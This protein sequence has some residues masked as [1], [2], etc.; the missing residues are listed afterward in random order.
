M[1]SSLVDEYY[2]LFALSP[3]GPSG[4]F[5]SLPLNVPIEARGFKGVTTITAIYPILPMTLL[6][7]LCLSSPL[8]QMISTF[9]E[10]LVEDFWL[11]VSLLDAIKSFSFNEVV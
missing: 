4:K 3:S 8:V 2:V 5:L 6:G 11:A 7:C 1:P 9:T 10:Q